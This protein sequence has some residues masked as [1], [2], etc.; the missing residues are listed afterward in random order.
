M[1][2]RRRLLYTVTV[3]TWILV[4]SPARSGAPDWPQFHG[5]NRDAKSTEV[6]LLPQWPSDGP[7]LLWTIKGLGAG[8]S[9]VSI[10]GG[11]L[12]T[13]GDVE[14]AP[15]HKEQVLLAFDLAT[16]EKLWQ[17]VV[18][19]PHSGGGPHCTPTV[20]GDRVY[21]LGTDGDLVC[22]ETAT[23][24]ILWRKKFGKDFDGKMMSGWRYSESP[25][26]DGK[27][28]VCTPGGNDAVL[29]A[30]DKITGSLIW[31]CA[32]PEIG[33]HGKDG[34]GYSSIVAADIDGIRQYVQLIGRGVIGVEAVTGKFLWGYNR[35]ANG[36]AN[37]TSP[38]VHGNYVFATTCYGSGSALLKITRQNDRM[39]AEEIYWLD[40][41]TFAN[42]HGGVVLVGDYL[43]G[44]DGQNKGAPVCLHFTTGKIAWKE[45]A[46]GRRSAAVLYADGHLYF[47]YEDGTMA[48]VEAR[49]DKFVLTGQFQLPSPDGPSWPHPVI[50]DKKLYIR[51]TNVLFCYDIAK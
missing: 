29:V 22:A 43:Y 50:H 41:K 35:V 19:P 32:L 24:K 3:G 51:D 20:D 48:L 33:A 42:H 46:I 16:R 30:L 13:M 18:G 10:A 17:A 14:T 1:T 11:K 40:S 49:P 28:L 45:K 9:S 6:G 15:K 4:A 36:T 25:L 34:A 38:V 27:K 44:G 31:K 26:I 47:R 8:Y 39:V 5:P 2:I 21:A 7:K 37:I 23:G 12:Y